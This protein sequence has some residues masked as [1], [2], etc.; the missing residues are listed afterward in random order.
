MERKGVQ[1][2]VVPVVESASGA[3]QER[4][5]VLRKRYGCESQA[6][7]GDTRSG[8]SRPG[9]CPW[10][11]ESHFAPVTDMDTSTPLG[12]VF[13]ALSSGFPTHPSR[14]DNCPS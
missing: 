14:T 13:A 11:P 5:S 4:T 10:S 12:R 9:N 3:D 1:E 8:I 7:G 6:S 2:I